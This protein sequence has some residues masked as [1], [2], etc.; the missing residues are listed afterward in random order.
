MDRLPRVV[1]FAVV[2]AALWSLTQP[3]RAASAPFCDDRGATALAAPPALEAP[4]EAVR[5]VCLSSCEH[6]LAPSDLCAAVHSQRHLP[7]PPPSDSDKALKASPA[8]S[9]PARACGMARPSARAE[10]PPCGI[11][12]RLERPPRA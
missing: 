3:A 12:V 10:S 4:D 6:E 7:A 1:L 8:L 9:G 11:H 5:R 2:L